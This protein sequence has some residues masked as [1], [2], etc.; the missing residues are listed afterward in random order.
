MTSGFGS[1][2]A[3]Q[4]FANPQPAPVPA[5]PQPAS[6]PTKQSLKS[7]WKGFRPPAKTA[8]PQGKYRNVSWFAEDLDDDSEMDLCAHPCQHMVLKKTQGREDE[9]YEAD[10]SDGETAP[11]S[12]S[13]L[14]NEVRRENTPAILP[15]DPS[16]LLDKC[17]CTMEPTL[18]LRIQHSSSS[19]NLGCSELCNPSLAQDHGSSGLVSGT[20]GVASYEESC[21]TLEAESLKTSCLSPF[22]SRIKCVKSRSLKREQVLQR[23]QEDT[24]QNQESERNSAKE[25]FATEERPTGIFGVPLRQSITYANVAISLVDDDGKS[26]IYGYVPIVVAKCG[27]FLKE[28][29]EYFGISSSEVV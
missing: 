15:A 8:E 6:P 7:W 24:N 27:V 29:G 10:A 16:S 26:Y 11:S 18:A 23:T 22:V 3:H 12:C 19:K 21:S 28:K 1:S 14:F 9:G 25:N 13:L 5:A 17:C 4:P 2:S 20:E